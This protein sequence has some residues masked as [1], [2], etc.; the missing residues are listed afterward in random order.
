M[1]LSSD[2]ATLFRETFAALLATEGG[3]AEMLD[4]IDLD[5]M[6]EAADFPLL[7]DNE[8]EAIRSQRALDDVRVQD[9]LGNVTED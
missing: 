5:Q 2:K 8:R 1:P 6:V 4:R 9:A 3:L 7:D